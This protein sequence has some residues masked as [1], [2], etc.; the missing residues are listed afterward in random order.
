MKKIKELRGVILAILIKGAKLLKFGKVL[1]MF[2]SMVVAFFAYGWA[3]GWIFAA[4]LIAMIFVHE[5]GHVIAIKMKGYPLK[6]PV[7]IPF[8]GAVIISPIPASKDEEAFV[9]IGGPVLGSIGALLAYLLYLTLPSHPPILLL[10][11]HLGIYINLINL[12]P[13]RPLDGGRIL[14]PL[15][16][17]KKYVFSAILMVVAIGVR[18]PVVLLILIMVIGD[19]EMPSLFKVQLSF[20]SLILMIALIA[21]SFNSQD[22]G[23]AISDIIIGLVFTGGRLWFHIREK[24]KKP[25]TIITEAKE[26][27]KEIECPVKIKVKWLLSYLILG[28]ILFA[29]WL[30]QKDEIHT[31]LT[32]R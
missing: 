19:I 3:L 6:L 18:E 12:I 20:A 17:W 28:G 30:L 14:H 4:A 24:E 15:G 1:L 22:P 7:F 32:A 2:G 27:T 9:G 5:L 25:T 31:L 13:M 23:S 11:G 10:A 8:V 26:P 29:L 21:F 16:S